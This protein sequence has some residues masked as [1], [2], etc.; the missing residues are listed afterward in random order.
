MLGKTKGIVL[1]TIKYSENSLILIVYTEE[2]GRQSYMLS[3]IHSK[4]SSG[5]KKLIHPL[6]LLSIDIYYK[7]SREL[8]KIKEYKS[9]SPLTGIHSSIVK[10]TIGLFIAEILYRTIKEEEKNPNLFTFLINSIQY[11]DFSDKGVEN[12]HL[13]FLIQLS[14]FLGFFPHD[15]YN[16][17]NAYFNFLQGS[18]VTFTENDN[19]LLNAS[20]SLWI[21]KILNMGYP[22]LLQLEITGTLRSILLDK[23]IQY[24]QAHFE[25]LGQIKSH[26][27]LLEVFQ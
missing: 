10:T 23:L 1:H 18:F 27:I 19:N 25:G 16:S 8:Q 12:F 13:V 21:H 11:L 26:K 15:N 14:K 6:S 17:D 24:Y 2:F 7:S 5:T 4:K 22:D 3:G 20:E 9:L